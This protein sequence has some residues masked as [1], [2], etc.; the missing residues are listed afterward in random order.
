MRTWDDHPDLYLSSISARR[1]G[2]KNWLGYAFVFWH[3]LQLQIS[4]FLVNAR[5]KN[6]D[7]RRAKH[8][9]REKAEVI[10]AFQVHAH[11]LQL[12]N[13]EA[14][15]GR[16]LIAKSDG[17]QPHR[18]EQ[19]LHAIRRL[20]VGKLEAGDRDHHFARGKDDVGE[21]LPSNVR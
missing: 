7:D 11:R 3:F 19:A 16:Q 21:E 12:R 5:D 18:H 10:R 20:R 13:E 14:D 17:E 8:E 4:T 6:V 1:A 2:G 15:H 9:E